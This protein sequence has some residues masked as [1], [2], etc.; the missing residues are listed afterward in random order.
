MNIHAQT[1]HNNLVFSEYTDL[2]WEAKTSQVHALFLAKQLLFI[3]YTGTLHSHTFSTFAWRSHKGSTAAS[4]GGCTTDAWLGGGELLLS[5]YPL[6]TTSHFPTT[7]TPSNSTQMRGM[8]KR[9]E[10]LI[11]SGQTDACASFAGRIL[12]YTYICLEMQP[13]TFYVRNLATY[14][15][16]TTGMHLYW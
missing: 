2:G 11:S 12:C 16:F 15:L 9:R 5:R 1:S 10:R 6:M 8:Q 3:M 4:P 14:D 7:G 13:P